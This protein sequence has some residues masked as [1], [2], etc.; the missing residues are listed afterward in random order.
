MNCRNEGRGGSGYLNGVL[1]VIAGL[2]VVVALRQSVGDGVGE[3]VAG[4]QAGKSGALGIPNAA[5]QRL[6]MLRAIERVDGRLQR[7]EKKLGGTLRV[8]VMSM[9]PVEVREK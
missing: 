8:E 4:G 1:T 5:A 9:P 7:M 6:D 2:L 3:A